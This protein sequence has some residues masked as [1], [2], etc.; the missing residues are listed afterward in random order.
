MLWISVGNTCDLIDDSSYNPN[1]CTTSNKCREM[2]GGC[3]SNDQC[4]GN[5]VCRSNFNSICGPKISDSKYC[6]HNPGN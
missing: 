3:V 4:T 2:Q 5:L 1:C 6:C